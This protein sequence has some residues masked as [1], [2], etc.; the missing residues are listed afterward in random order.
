LVSVTRGNYVLESIP[1]GVPDPVLAGTFDPTLA[2]S[3]R[4]GKI[5]FGVY[6]EQSREITG[7]V[8]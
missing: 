3:A 7:A 5:V 6:I 1:G 2:R 8:F 4:A